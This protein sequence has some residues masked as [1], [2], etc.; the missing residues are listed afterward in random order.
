M[1]RIPTPET[2]HFRGVW[3][4]ECIN[5]F[6]IYDVA[7]RLEYENKLLRDTLEKFRGQFDHN[8]CSGTAEDVLDSLKNV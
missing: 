6:T 7:V 8:S 4:T 5:N 1:S 3:A 2:K